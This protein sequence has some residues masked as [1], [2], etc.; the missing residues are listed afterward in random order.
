[1]IR[2]E[3]EPRAQRPLAPQTPVVVRTEETLYET[4]LRLEGRVRVR[5]ERNGRAGLTRRTRFE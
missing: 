1:M 2:A 4:R 5:R 3:P